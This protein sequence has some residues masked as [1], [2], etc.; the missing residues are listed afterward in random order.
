MSISQSAALTLLQPYLQSIGRCILDGWAVYQEK[1]IEVAPE[2]STT[3]R[4]SIIR[5]H[6]VARIRRAF[7]GERNI[8]IIEKKNGLFCL[9]IDQIIAIRFKKLDRNKWPATNA[10][11]QSR[12]FIE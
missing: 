12:T 11:R 4:P 10:T 9:V 7:D 2:H 5:D 1:Y 8:K 3:T 6:I